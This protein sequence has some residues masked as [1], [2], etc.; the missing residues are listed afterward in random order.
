M[1]TVFDFSAEDAK[2][3]NVALENYRGKVLLIVNT[4]S[5][6][7]FTPQA[8]NPP[9]SPPGGGAMNFD[10]AAGD[11]PRDEEMDEPNSHNDQA[12]ALKDRL[13]MAHAE[14]VIIRERETHSIAQERIKLEAEQQIAVLT[15]EIQAQKSIRL[16]QSAA[17]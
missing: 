15:N 12:V 5:K 7:G 1:T 3:D 6:C 11:S 2:G 9:E 17:H 4:A 8:P 16:C 10:L 13:V 14:L